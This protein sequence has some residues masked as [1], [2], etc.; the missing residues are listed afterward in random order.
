VSGA[1]AWVKEQYSCAESGS[2][3]MTKLDAMSVAHLSG[4]A[5][6]I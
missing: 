5:S 6:L 1:A 3:E 4:D 2:R